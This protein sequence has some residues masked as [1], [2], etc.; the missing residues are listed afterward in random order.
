MAKYKDKAKI[1]IFTIFEN[2]KIDLKQIFLLE[3]MHHISDAHI[4]LSPNTG[5]LAGNI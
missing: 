3:V 4:S 2:K 1:P 5:T